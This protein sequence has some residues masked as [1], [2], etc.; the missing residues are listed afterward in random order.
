MEILPDP[1]EQKAALASLAE[2]ANARLETIA[3]ASSS[4]A[5]NVGCS[6]GLMPG[7]FIVALVF[8][9]SRGSIAAAAIAFLLVSL[10]L[11]LFANVIAYIARSKSVDRAYQ[12]EINLEI[13]LSLRE[14]SFSRNTF[15]QAAGQVL[16]AEAALRKYLTSLQPKIEDKEVSS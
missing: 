14:G 12:D 7:L 11:V 6:V 2:S 10:F 16:P 15:E 13:E 5:F 1:E 3:A 8:F 9:L 4:Q